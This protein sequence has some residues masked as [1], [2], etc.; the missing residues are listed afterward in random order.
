MRHTWPLSCEADLRQKASV[1][2]ELNFPSS[3]VFVSKKMA[4]TSCDVCVEEKREPH[5][6][7]G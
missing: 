6:L 7:N 2:P 4:D 3:Y 1:S 5:G